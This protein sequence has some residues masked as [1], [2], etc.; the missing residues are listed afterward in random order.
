MTTKPGLAVAQD[1]LNSFTNNNMSTEG[2]KGIS[3]ENQKAREI[4]RAGSF[5]GRMAC[6]SGVGR[7]D[8]II[9]FQPSMYRLFR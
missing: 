8:D 5:F 7:E 4:I 3:S 1:A 6:G 9:I 2:V